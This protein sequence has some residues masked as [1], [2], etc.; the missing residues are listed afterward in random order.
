ME[1][2]HKQLQNGRNICAYKEK[3][4]AC[5]GIDNAVNLMKGVGGLKQYYARS[6]AMGIFRC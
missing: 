3:R 1:V 5:G 2:N 4:H 6:R